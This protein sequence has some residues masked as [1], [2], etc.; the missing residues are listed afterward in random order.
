MTELL[1]DALEICALHRGAE[2]IAKFRETCKEASQLPM[3]EER[4]KAEYKKF[5]NGR[6]EILTK[7]YW[8][9]DH[10]KLNKLTEELRYTKHLNTPETNEELFQEIKTLERKIL[11]IHRKIEFVKSEIS[12]M[13]KSI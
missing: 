9:F 12:K 4:F 11:R 6:L 2:E 13:K 8:G 7:E 1:F 5:L 3:L 10:R